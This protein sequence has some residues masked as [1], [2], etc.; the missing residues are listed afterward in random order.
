MMSLKSKNILVTGASGFLGRNLI[1]KFL[2]FDYKVYAMSSKKHLDNRELRNLVYVNNKKLK[3]FDFSKIDI[4]INCAFSRDDNGED[5]AKALVFTKELFLEA[6][7]K[8]VKSIIN[9]SSQSVYTKYRI[10][11]AKETDIINLD[12]KYAVGKYSCELLL[13]SICDIKGIPYT[14]IRL[15]SLIGQ[16][17]NQRLF[18]IIL[19]NI[20]QGKD[21][22]F[23]SGKQIFEYLDIRDAVSALGAIIRIDPKKWNKFYNLGSSCAINMDGIV[24]MIK[25]YIK[26]HEVN[27]KIEKS[28]ILSNNSIDSSLF[29][30]DINW[31]PKFMLED[32]ISWIYEGL[33][34]S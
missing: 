16:N 13:E 15:A 8:N 10:A 31:K 7:K 1:E 17:F 34:N 11:P 30:N 20:I 25:P 5:L 3:E 6:C 12:S 23:Y 2:E 21:I 27:F 32:S 14:N 33:K 28:D 4:L 26:V 19:N 22:T 29:Y 24:N 9:I 18:N